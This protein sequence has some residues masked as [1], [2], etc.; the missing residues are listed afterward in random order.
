[1]SE[2]FDIGVASIPR[3]P[4]DSFTCTACSGGVFHVLT[5]SKQVLLYTVTGDV[6]VHRET[7]HLK[8]VPH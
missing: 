6:P 4:H 5:S 1:M 2:C 7:Q 8:I 3:G